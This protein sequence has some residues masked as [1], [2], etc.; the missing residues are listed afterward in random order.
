MTSD[1]W[2]P[3]AS[4]AAPMVQPPVTTRPATSQCAAVAVNVRLGTVGEWPTC[5]V[6]YTHDAF[7]AVK[8]TGPG[9]PRAST[10]TSPGAS[11]APAADAMNA[12]SVPPAAG[13]R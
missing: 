8:V 11:A 9:L 12:A 7:G 3:S 10:T 13:S 2:W 5:A 1:A 6:T 4:D